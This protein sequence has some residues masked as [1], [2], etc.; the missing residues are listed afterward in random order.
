MRAVY[1]CHGIKIQIMGREFDAIIQCAKRSVL[2]T[3]PTGERF[4]FVATPP[5]SIDCVVNQMK[6]DLIEDIKITC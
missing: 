6:A 1:Q 3:S 4:E 2:L 5:T